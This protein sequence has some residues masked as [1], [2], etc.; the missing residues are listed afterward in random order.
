VQNIKSKR[1]KTETGND[2]E[3]ISA[4]SRQIYKDL[5]ISS[6]KVTKEE[7]ENIP[8]HMLDI[9]NPGEYFSVVD[10][11]KM[12]LQKISEIYERGNTPIICGG[13][14]LYIDHI[15]YEI[16]LPNVGKDEVLRN[17]L[18]NKSSDE[19]FEI[20]KKIAEPK[21]ASQFSAPEFKNNKHRL[22][23]AIEIIKQ[24]G[25]YPAS[26]KK[27]RFANA[28]IIITTLDKN[29]FKNKLTERLSKRLNDGMINEIELVKN[30][31]DLSHEYLESLGLEFRFISLF[32]QN[33]ISYEKMFGLLNTAIYQY[34][35][36]QIT[37]FK[38][39]S[40]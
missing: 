2:C 37:W 1:I 9:V 14:G 12:A 3:I 17:E 34:S 21:I 40:N 7:M 18:K 8:H 33:K 39:Y 29:L 4:D 5:N 23:R 32:L 35:K 22:V 6:G 30:K 38:K 24:L 15:F 27:Q 20:L 28:E 16:N 19:L 36:R 13:T 31:Y 10:F 26:E 25:Y 11:E